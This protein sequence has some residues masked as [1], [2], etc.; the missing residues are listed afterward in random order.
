MKLLDSDEATP[1]SPSRP[2]SRLIHAARSSLRAAVVYASALSDRFE[3]ACASEPNQLD[4]IPADLLLHLEAVSDAFQD[5][6]RRTLWFIEPELA[7]KAQAIAG[8]AR[9]G[10][11]DP[12]VEN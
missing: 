3:V 6:A 7:Q 1:G 10:A 11:G 12:P 5:G 9:E 4:S 2:P 8:L